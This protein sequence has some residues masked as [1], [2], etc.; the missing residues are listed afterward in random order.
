VFRYCD[1]EDPSILSGSSI[2]ANVNAIGMGLDVDG[3]SSIGMA[4]DAVYIARDLLGLPPVPTSF[5]L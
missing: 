1:S 4:T 3:N 2:V 5:R